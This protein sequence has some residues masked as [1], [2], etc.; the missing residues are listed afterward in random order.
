MS[1]S[2]GER[3]RD[4]IISAI[5]IHGGSA[6]V[7]EIVGEVMDNRNNVNH[8]IRVLRGLEDSDV[9]DVD[10]SDPQVELDGTEA[11]PGN[12]IDANIY[13]LTDAGK[14]RLERLQDDGM[15]G[16]PSREVVESVMEENQQI[17]EELWSAEKEIKQLRS[18]FETFRESHN[19]LVD[20]LEDAGVIR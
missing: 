11:R 13:R 18:D 19:K 7:G 17:R 14:D 15:A 1:K 20:R 16:V 3:R 5:Y 6:T 10:R 12:Q 2:K 9:G 8:H 4:G